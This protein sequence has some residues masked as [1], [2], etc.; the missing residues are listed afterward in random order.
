MLCRGIAQTEFLDA[1]FGLEVEHLELGEFIDH[2]L[3]LVRDSR[4]NRYT[5]GS[6]L[7]QVFIDRL[8]APESLELRLSERRNC[9]AS[10]ILRLARNGNTIAL[11]NSTDWRSS[12]FSRTSSC[13]TTT[14]GLTFSRPT[15]SAWR[16]RFPCSSCYDGCVRSSV[17]I[18]GDANTKELFRQVSSRVTACRVRSSI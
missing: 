17:K 8:R 7:A 13:L 11:T 5:L 15:T 18:F 1:V 12:A 3:H 16:L 14:K 9:T 2:G 4:L 10:P 6:D